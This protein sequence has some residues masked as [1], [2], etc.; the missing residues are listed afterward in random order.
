MK[1]KTGLTTHTKTLK[2]A[3]IV[4]SHDETYHLADIQNA[5]KAAHGGEVTVRCHRGSLNEIW[6]HFNVAGRLQTGR[7]EP[8]DA[9]ESKYSSFHYLLLFHSKQKKSIILM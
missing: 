7:F 1:K 2:D 8:T 5:L 3:G 4:P 9:G 6:Y